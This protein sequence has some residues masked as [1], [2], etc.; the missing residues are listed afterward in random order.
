MDKDKQCPRC[1]RPAHR[2]LSV[3]ESRPDGT[4]TPHP[5]VCPT[6]AS[7][8]ADVNVLHVEPAMMPIAIGLRLLDRLTRKATDRALDEIERKRR[9]RAG[10]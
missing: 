6:C 8:I 5:E 2:F 4:T 10:T 3:Q 9:R 1:K 7:D